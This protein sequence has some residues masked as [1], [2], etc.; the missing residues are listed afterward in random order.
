L[1]NMSGITQ[2]GLAEITTL[3]AGTVEANSVQVGGDVIVNGEITTR[4]ATIGSNSS[5][6]HTIHGTASFSNIA[7]VSNFYLP[8]YSSITTN[9]SSFSVAN[10]QIRFTVGSSS[11]VTP[12]SGAEYDGYVGLWSISSGPITFTFSFGTVIF[13]TGDTFFVYSINGNWYCDKKNSAV[14][15]SISISSNTTVTPTASTLLVTNTSGSS[16]TVTLSGGYNGMVV[17]VCA[18]TDTISVLGEH[19]RTTLYAGASCIAKRTSDGWYI[20]SDAY[21]TP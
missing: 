7:A 8:S 15:Q 6:I 13:Q 19:L 21:L 18:V 16:K 3:E 2:L 17:L 14:E 20:V 1:S 9:S 4:N 5:S 11:S 12:P 10:S